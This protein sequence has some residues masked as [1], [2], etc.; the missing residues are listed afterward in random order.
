MV[1]IK[2]TTKVVKQ[3]NIELVT[4][5]MRELGQATRSE[6]AAATGLSVATCGNILKELVDEG[7]IWEGDLVESE[8]GRPSRQFVFNAN[9]SMALCIAIMSDRRYHMLSYAVVNLQGQV[10]DKGCA[11]HDMITI[12]IID[13]L[14]EEIIKKNSAVKIIS[15]GIPGMVRDGIV[16]YCD[17]EDLNGIAVKDILSDKYNLT[18]LVENEMHL[19]AYGY[20]KGNPELNGNPIAVLF[21]PEYH[22]IGAGFIIDGQI[23]KGSSN[24]SGEISYLPFGFSRDEL[25]KQCNDEKTFTRIIAKTATSIIPIINP[26]HLVLTGSLFRPEMVEIIRKLCS[27]IIPEEFL[28]EFLFQ[29]D[30]KEDYLK[31]NI[32]LALESLTGGIQLIKK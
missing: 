28:P 1:K 17:T 3:T 18:V 6:I 26:S 27:E 8:G 10:I 4:E 16:K 25:I 5:T 9:Y 29:Q 2:N 14:I 24:L 11:T 19:M 22:L 13:N 15:I 32:S 12:E 20:Y 7:K 31:G 21:A 30:L 23:L